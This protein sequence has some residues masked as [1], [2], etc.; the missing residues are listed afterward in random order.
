MK[1]KLKILKKPTHL[2]I[3]QIMEIY[4]DVGWWYFYDNTKRLKK[5]IKGSYLFFV[6]KYNK[7]I[8]A[9]ARVISDS[10]NDAYI[11]DFAV[12]KK[13]RNKKIGQRLLKFIIKTLKKRGFKWIGLISEKKPLSLYKR[14]GFKIYKNKIP[15]IYEIKKVK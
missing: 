13:F 1:I 8:I 5:I 14:T 7:K 15:M 9:M 2:D 11:Q 12:L 6:V 10:I 4:K 3:N